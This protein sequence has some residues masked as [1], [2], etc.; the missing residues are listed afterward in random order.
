MRFFALLHITPLRM[1][2][3]NEKVF[4]IASLSCL[5]FFV[6]FF[7]ALI[8]SLFLYITPNTFISIL[9]SDE[10][11][12]AIKLSLITATITTFLSLIL[13]IPAAYSLSRI[14][15]KG[16]D[17]IDTILDLPIVV[18]PIALGAALL[19]FFNTPMGNIMNDFFVF[20]VYG[21]VVAQFTIV[22]ALCIRLMKSTFDSIDPRYEKM[23]RVLGCNK[24]QAFYKI[25]LPL[26]KNGL[27]S[28]GILTW[29][30]AIGE[31]GATITLSGATKMKTETLPI[32]IFLNLAS[33]EVEKSIV[34]I[35]ILISIAIISLFLLRRV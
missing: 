26:A 35:L 4:K 33:A 12:F 6:L 32:A 17:F 3:T 11:L 14:E 13:G 24:F 15:F 19:I 22:S 29:A 23:A 25:T 1:R 31:F 30:R 9:F 5:V 34:V 2:I 16:K 8:V 18:S 7:I 20:T 28:S 21:I 10:I 27:L